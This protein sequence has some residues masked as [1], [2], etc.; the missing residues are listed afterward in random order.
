MIFDRVRFRD[1]RR[2][3]SKKIIFS[4]F[5]VLAILLIFLLV[6]I[7]NS[8]KNNAGDDYGDDVISTIVKNQEKSTFNIKELSIKE[9]KDRIIL[10]NVYSIRDFSY[11]FSLDLADKLEKTYKNKVVIID[12]ILDE[13]NTDENLIINY[14]IKNNIERPVIKMP[15]FSIGDSKNHDKYLALIDTDGVVKNIFYSKEIEENNII[16]AI[17]SI[18]EKK[19]KINNNKLENLELEKLSRPEAFIK[20]LSYIKYLPK[21]DGVNDVPYFIVSD[22]SGRKIYFMTINGNIINQIGNGLNGSN[23]GFGINASFCHPAGLVVDNNST[24]YVADMCNNSI[25]KVDLKTMEVSTLLRDEQ[26]LIRPVDLEVLN[27][28]LI[29]SIGGNNSLIKYSFKSG[30]VSEVDFKNKDKSIAKLIKYD[31]KLYFIGSKDYGLYALNKEGK[32]EKEIDFNEL[33]D[34]NDIKIEGNNNFHIDD[35]G[36]YIVD[37]FNNRILRIL[38]GKT[39]NYSNNNSAKIYNLP[40][41]MVDVKDKLYITNENDKKLI[42]LDKK[43]QETKVVNINFGYEYNRI[44]NNS[45]EFLNVNNLRKIYLK[46]GDNNKIVIKL[47]NGY[48]FENMAPQSL[49]LYKEDLENNS[50]ILIK[51]YTKNEIMENNILD[52]PELDDGLV[53]YIKGNFYY[54]NYEKKTP[55]LIRKYDRKIKAQNDSD[56]SK[57]VIDFVY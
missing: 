17:N 24:L 20:S 38:K 11:I 22:S 31:N 45:E 27:G 49:N 1:R 19:P 3:H 28:N 2:K 9:L 29:I 42:Q 34:K 13:F 54:C 52:I 36:L 53:Y 57:I 40:T 5:I 39:I 23:D 51:S 15:D 30:E 47:E 55:C 18:L 37:K 7:S 10:L 44:K 48:S 16:N 25:R 41:D 50:A 14:I 35:T 8:G 4:V 56:N 33:N 26:L 46:S 21:T 12:I 6:K 32:I 43:T